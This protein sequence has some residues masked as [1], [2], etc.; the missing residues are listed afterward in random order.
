MCR[1]LPQLWPLLSV[2]NEGVAL[3]WHGHTACI[4]QRLPCHAEYPAALVSSSH[5]MLSTLLALVSSCHVMPSTL[6]ALVSSCHV[7]LSTLLALVSSCHVMHTT[8]CS[9]SSELKVHI[10]M[11]RLNSHHKKYHEICRFGV[12]ML[13][14]RPAIASVLHLHNA[15]TMLHDSLGQRVF[16]AHVSCMPHV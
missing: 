16:C 6:L 15:W 10:D 14:A 7:M 12:G 1:R 11:D 9:S 8:S 4:S 3:L 13:I 5:V 2:H